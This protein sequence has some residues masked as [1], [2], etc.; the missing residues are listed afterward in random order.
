MWWSQSPRLSAR[1]GGLLFERG[2]LDEDVVAVACAKVLVG[3]EGSAHHHGLAHG[4][5][6]VGRD[7][8]VVGPVGFAARSVLEVHEGRAHDTS[9]DLG[10]PPAHRDR[11]VGERRLLGEELRHGLTAG[12]RLDRGRGGSGS[13][14]RFK[15]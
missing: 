9:S 6:V 1:K 3:D 10:H 8:E 5:R 7:R 15:K 12:E 4:D 13:R 2:V 11:L 14:C